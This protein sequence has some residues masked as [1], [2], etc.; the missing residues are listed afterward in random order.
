MKHKQEETVF[1]AFRVCS[2]KGGFP[3]EDAFNAKLFEFESK[4]RV[5]CTYLRTNEAF[6]SLAI[7]FSPKIF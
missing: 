6:L 5:L 3:K 1:G 7:C 2:S 4:Q